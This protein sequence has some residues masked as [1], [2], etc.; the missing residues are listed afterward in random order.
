MDRDTYVD[1][2]TLQISVPELNTKGHCLVG[3]SFGQTPGN[4]S[5]RASTKAKLASCSTNAT[6]VQT[7]K[8]DHTWVVTTDGSAG[9]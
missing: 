5:V 2:A 7:I 8:Q 9:F 6:D 3:V 1:A 4:F